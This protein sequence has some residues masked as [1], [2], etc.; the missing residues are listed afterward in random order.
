MHI[1][2]VG[3]QTSAEAGRRFALTGRLKPP[4]STV[5]QAF[6]RKLL[7]RVNFTT[8][9]E[10]PIV[11]TNLTIDEKL[12]EEARKLG[13]HRIRKETV[14]A[15]LKEY[16]KRRRQHAILS[17]FGSIDYDRNYDY[18]RERAARKRWTF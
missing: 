11:A 5:V 4:S 3:S 1:E 8:W 18:K 9:K 15:A 12:I 6:F 13:H 14:T 10:E 17:L 2:G 16:I 7:K